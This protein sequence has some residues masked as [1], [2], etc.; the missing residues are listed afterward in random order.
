MR[1]LRSYADDWR[2]C[3]RIKAMRLLALGGA[4]QGAVVACPAA[5]S[6]HLPTWVMQTASSIAFGCMILAGLGIGKQT[7]PESHDVHDSDAPNP[8]H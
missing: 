6:D 1:G 2:R 4:I 5:I 7:R 3:W 8:G